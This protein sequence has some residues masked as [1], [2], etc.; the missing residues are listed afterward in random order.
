MPLG[1]KL[2]PHRQ[3]RRRRL[4]V[5]LP[6]EQLGPVRPPQAVISSLHALDRGGQRA[7]VRAEV[8]VDDAEWSRRH[9]GKPDGCWIQ[10]AGVQQQR[11]AAH[12]A[13]GPGGEQRPTRA[14]L[15]RGD[16]LEGDAVVSTL[17]VG[18]HLPRRGVVEPQPTATVVDGQRLP[19]GADVQTRDRVAV[20]GHGAG[21]LGTLLQHRLQVRAGRRRVVHADAG[22]REQHR[23][24]DVVGRQGPGTGAAGLGGRLG[25]QRRTRVGV[26]PV[27]LTDGEASRDQRGDQQHH[28]PGEQSTLAADQAGLDPRPDLCFAPFGLF[29]LLGGVE[30][31]G[32]GLGQGRRSARSPLEG[33]AQARSSVQLAVRAAEQVPGVGRTAEVVQD[34][35]TFDVLLE[36]ALQPGPR[37]RQRLV[38]D[39]HDAG[40]T[41]D[42]PGAHQQV[43]EILVLATARQQASRHAA[44][45]RFALGAGRDQ[46]EHEVA[47]HV[48]LVL[49]DADVHRLR[50]SG[51]GAANA[52]GCGVPRHGQGAALTSVPGL[53][54]G[55]GHERQCAGSTGDLADEQVDQPGFDQQPGL[56]RRFLDGLAQ[57]LLAHATE[58]VQA[59]LD[60]P[61]EAGVDRHL[62]HPVGAHGHHHGPGTYRPARQLGEELAPL[63]LVATEREDLLALV[64]HQHVARRRVGCSR[65]RTHGVLSWGQHDD[66]AALMTQRRGDPR[67]DQRRLAASRGTDHGQRARAPE[68]VEADEQVGL[69]SEERLGVVHVVRAQAAVGADRAGGE[70]PTDEQRVVLPEDRLFQRGQVGAGVQAELVGQQRLHPSDRAQRL[71]LAAR[72][73]LRPREQRPA[74]LA[75]RGRLH[76]ALRHRQHVEVQPCSQGR[77]H[78]E[79]LR[80]EPELLE[81]CRLDHRRVP[82]LDVLVRR[83]APEVERLRHHRRGALRLA[84]Q[85]QLLAAQGQP[86]EAVRVDLL[87]GNLQRVAVGRGLDVSRSQLA[88]QPHDAALQGLARRGRGLVAPHGLGE[89]VGTDRPADVQRQGAEHGA[90]PAADDT[91]VAGERAE[92]TDAHSRTVRPCRRGVNRGITAGLPPG[93]T[94]DGSP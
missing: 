11:R 39:L 2:D 50:R 92:H 22:H 86:L 7:A 90:V 68:Q 16:P 43:D 1:P 46:A 80:L 64:D 20:V 41:G 38:G 94:P 45:H 58:Q 26:G 84:E 48:P 23:Q 3:H 52:A 30:E 34:P 10:R 76:H 14:E 89:L 29:R 81:P 70:Q 49:L 47:Q 63:T 21:Q 9:P 65:Q 72:L 93:A 27:G 82:R 25:G 13:A 57:R 77:V 17:L 83:P 32:L 4:G 85:Q 51:D 78:P 54:Q 91:P 37:A 67:A 66:G 75:Q 40:V 12:H 55:V 74:P 61:G 33:P 79:L 28:G 88:A 59:A 31:G 24:V 87:G 73:V 56:A 18:E 60:Q 35:L 6:H 42:Q 8:D 62:R 15:E 53:H 19:V 71:G 36:P 69:A 5:Q 44:P